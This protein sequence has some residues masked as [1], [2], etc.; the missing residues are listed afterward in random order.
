MKLMLV[1][2]GQTQW[3]HEKRVQGTSDIP[4]NTLGLTQVERLA[5]SLRV[6]PIDTIVSSPL[7]RAIQ[8]AN[9][10]NRFHR[11]P[12]IIDDN[13]MELDQGDFEGRSFS[14]LLASHADFLKQWARDPASVTMPNGESLANLQRRAWSAVESLPA[15]AGTVLFVSHNFT[16]MTI[17]CKI[18]GI[19]LNRIREAHVSPASV[20]FVDVEDGRGKVVSFNETSH[21][22][23]CA[24][25]VA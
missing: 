10:V 23:G 17:L 18:N 14:D 9:A 19:N 7:K 1:R 2:H 24:E 22:A 16:I 12:V 11:L 5:E 8:T 25:T 4:L 6:L 21:L 13:L 20:T 15:S 3:N